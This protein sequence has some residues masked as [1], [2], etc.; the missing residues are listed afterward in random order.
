[1]LKN[2]ISRFALLIGVALICTQCKF[3]QYEYESHR[4]VN[5]PTQRF[6][7]IGDIRIEG[8]SNNPLVTYDGL[9]RKARKEYGPK[10]DV[11]DVRIDRVNK[12]LGKDKIILNAHVIRY[13]DAY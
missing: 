10:V 12:A 11:I 1:M 7:L 3:Y 8:K 2:R 9:L 5:L 13:F 4:S 6:Q